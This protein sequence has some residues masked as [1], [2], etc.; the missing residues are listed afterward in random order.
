MTILFRRFFGGEKLVS[1][2]GVLSQ[3]F[4]PSNF[5]ASEEGLTNDHLPPNVLLVT[6]NG[7]KLEVRVC[8]AYAI[9]GSN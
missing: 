8:R 9:H 2:R 7:E 4:T 3:A 5:E 1:R 6:I